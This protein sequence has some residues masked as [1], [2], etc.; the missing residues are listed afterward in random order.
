MEKTRSAE[1]HVYEKAEEDE[2]EPDLLGE[3]EKSPR[4]PLAK[5]G[6]SEGSDGEE[7]TEEGSDLPDE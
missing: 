2:E 5:E 4:N 7:S 1:E 6:E 3:F